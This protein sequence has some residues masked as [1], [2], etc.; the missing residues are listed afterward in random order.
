VIKDDEKRLRCQSLDREFP[1]SYLENSNKERL[2]LEHITKY[3]KTFLNIYG[4]RDYEL[5]LKAKNEFGVEKLICSTIRPTKLG[6]VSLFDFKKCSE[7]LSNFIQYERLSFENEYPSIVPSPSNVLKWQKGDSLDISILL[8]SL[9]L[10]VGF[11]VYV[12]VGTAQRFITEKR[13]EVNF[14]GITA[15]VSLLET[16]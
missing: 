6:Y 2:I 13:V 9:L 10:G 11:S 3:E 15:R 7:F 14:I 16:A 5:F 4:K 12:V 8:A 1:I